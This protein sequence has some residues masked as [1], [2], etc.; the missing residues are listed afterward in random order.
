MDLNQTGISHEQQFPPNSMWA[1][2]PVLSAEN[3][4]SMERAR[5]VGPYLG[6]TSVRDKVQESLADAEDRPPDN[7]ILPG[8]ELIVFPQ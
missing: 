7:P 8:D 2:E 5:R 3:L 1:V 6:S 4:R